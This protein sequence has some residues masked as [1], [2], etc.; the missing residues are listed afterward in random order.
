MANFIQKVL[1][2]K[3]LLNNMKSNVDW[4]DQNYRLPF[5]QAENYFFKMAQY[6]LNKFYFQE[7]YNAGYIN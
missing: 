6:F 7:V 4:N 5:S 3:S 2:G 1:N